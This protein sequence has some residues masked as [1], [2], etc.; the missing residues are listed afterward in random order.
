MSA[1][2]AATG[3]KTIVIQGTATPKLGR[4]IKAAGVKA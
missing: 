2:S 1:D 3:P 4:V